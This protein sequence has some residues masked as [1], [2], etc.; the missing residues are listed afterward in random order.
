M[1][2]W[3]DADAC[4]VVIKEIIFRAAQRTQT[5]AIF[6]ANHDVKVPPSNWLAKLQVSGG[7]DVADHEIERRVMSGDI[8]VTADIP[9]ADAVIDKNAHVISPRGERLTKENIKSRLNIRDF[10][11][12]LRASGVHTGGPPPLSHTDRKTF[13]D[14]LDT[15]LRQK[16]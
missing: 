6:V 2:I 5:K 15:I 13:A 8:V 10:M 16:T 14:M 3:I 12:T 1:Q 11:E 7:Y 4:P 9:L